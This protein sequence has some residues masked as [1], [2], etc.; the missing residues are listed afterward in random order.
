M[1]ISARPAGDPAAGRKILRRLFLLL[2]VLVFLL[3]GALTVFVFLKKPHI[4]YSATNRPADLIYFATWLVIL[5]AGIVACLWRR[6]LPI[7][8]AVF[9]LLLAE[10]GAQAY[11]FE[12]TG[13][14]YQPEPPPAEQKFEPHPLLVGIP[15]PGNFAGLV[16]DA[17]HRRR[18][19]NPDKAAN[20]R[21]IFAFGGSTTYDLANNDAQTWESDLSRRLGA[22][23]A[24][25]N[26]GVPGY[27][28]VENLIQ[29]LFAFRDSPPACALYF[30][31]INDLRNAH[32]EGLKADY[33][34]FALPAQRHNLGLAYPGFLVNNL[35]FLRSMIALVS[36]SHSDVRGTVGGEADPRLSAIFSQ[37]MRLIGAIGR[38][39]GVRVVFIPAVANWPVLEG[40]HT[41]DWFEFVEYKDIKPLLLAMSRDL[42][43]AADASGAA[44]IGA[45]LEQDWTADDFSDSAH[46]NKAGAEKFAASIA[47]A[48]ADLCR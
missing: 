20:A 6:G 37:N 31:G 41:R 3:L 40:S 44:Y 33:S 46:F 21:V 43:N 32:I 35:L 36:P 4:D 42:K 5:M 27:S 10:A 1:P 48:V 24:V 2:F 16:Q 7:A 45:P 11:V 9:L 30:E 15:R 13:A 19:D 28:S 8:F 26:L 25:E 47:G 18:T 34:D 38:Q 14:I 12:T 29:S 23:F 17:N 39:F 22:G